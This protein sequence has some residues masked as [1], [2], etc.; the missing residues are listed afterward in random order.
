MSNVLEEIDR[1]RHIAKINTRLLY[2]LSNLSHKLIEHARK[3]NISF[4]REEII[5]L[6]EEAKQYMNELDMPTSV[7]K[8]CSMCGKLN[9]ENATFCTHC[10]TTLDVI[11][12]VRHHS[13][14]THKGDTTSSAFTK[15]I[16]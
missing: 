7:N 13:D 4:P 14:N 15:Y 6:I 8:P 9:P 16:I 1:I 10:G 5:P 3:N 11:S 12:R 2:T